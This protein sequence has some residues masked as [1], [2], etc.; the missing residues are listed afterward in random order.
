M[1]TRVKKEDMLKMVNE[2]IEAY[3]LDE[4]SVYEIV[5]KYIKS[6]SVF[7]SLNAQKY[8]QDNNIDIEGLA[9]TGK[10]GK[11]TVRDLKTRENKAESPKHENAEQ[12]FAKKIE[13][14]H[15]HV[16]THHDDDNTSETVSL[17][18]AMSPAVTPKAKPKEETH[19]TILKSQKEE[20]QPVSVKT[21]KEW[22]HTEP[23]SN[24]HEVMITKA[25]KERLGDRPT[26]NIKGSGK[27][28][29]ITVKDIN[30]YLTSES[31]S[32]APVTPTNAKIRVSEPKSPKKV[33][34]TTKMTVS[35]FQTVLPNDEEDLD[36][37]KVTE[38]DESE[39][40]N[41]QPAPEDM[42]F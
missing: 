17:P 39:E 20:T 10:N 24:E 5:D 40:L 11:L 12:K 16:A 38:Q 26:P 34:K 3:S 4:E 25:A 28:G 37:P 8:A 31:G 35:S 33:V 1:A 32:Q 6:T 21:Q 18:S 22:V 41:L 30:T 7:A 14:K 36:Q 19:F 42:D 2:I 13:V 27:N 9:G 15:H 29:V 23:T